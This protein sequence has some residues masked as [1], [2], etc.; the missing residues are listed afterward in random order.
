VNEFVDE[1]RGEW[2][3][4]RVPDPVA[5]EM[6]ADLE[7]DLRQAEAE[8]ATAED[9]LGAAAFDPRPFAASWA[10]ERGVIPPP[11][12]TS[13]SPLSPTPVRRPR[14]LGLA[15]ALAVLVV[16]VG[17]VAG[18]S[19]TSFVGTRSAAGAPITAQP[20]APPGVRFL[21]FPV[22]LPRGAPGMIFAVSGPGAPGPVL[23]ALGAILVVAGI[24]VVG[25]VLLVWARSVRA[26]GSSGP[27]ADGG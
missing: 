3:R 17:L 6:A 13:A 16:G 25:L 20:V 23:R 18:V 7:A 14:L 11:L 19:S 24:G 21:P 4:L 22:P 15:A 27:S 12:A 2:R 10:A 5:N 9:V 1:C 26:R 8:G